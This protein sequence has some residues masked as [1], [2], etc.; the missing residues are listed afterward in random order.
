[1]RILILGGSKSGKSMLAQRLARGIAAGK[2]LYYWATMEPMDGEDDARIARHRLERDGW[3]FETVEWGRNLPAALPLIVSAGTVLFD[4]ITAALACE[5]F[6]SQDVDP[7]ASE[8]LCRDLLTVSTHPQN[9]VCVC[10]EVFR[11]G[12]QFDPLTENYRRGLALVCRRAAEEFDLVLEVAA[13]LP[14]FWKGAD[15]YGKMVGRLLHG[16]GN[17]PGDPQSPAP[18]E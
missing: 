17:V 18:V 8:R 11:D 4:S 7:G 1:M 9:F 15:K 13:G 2:K 10:D 12:I 3:G 16:L 14:H 5:M 6:S